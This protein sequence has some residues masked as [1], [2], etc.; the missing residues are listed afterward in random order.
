ML[1]ESCH[2]EYRPC[3]TVEQRETNSVTKSGD[4]SHHFPLKLP[5]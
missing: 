4:G 1:I 3:M 5:W 2:I